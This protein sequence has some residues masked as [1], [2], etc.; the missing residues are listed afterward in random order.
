[1]L[2]YS[3]GTDSGKIFAIFWSIFNLSAVLGGFITFVYFSSTSSSGNVALFFIFLGLIMAGAFGALG[4]EAPTALLK[5]SPKTSFSHDRTLTSPILSEDDDT[6]DTKQPE[7]V[8]SGII[9]A[10]EE[11]SDESWVSE[12]GATVILFTDPRMARMALI[13]FYTG[14]NQPY[15]LVTFGNRFF[16]PS[17]LGLMVALFYSAE[18]VGAFVSAKVVDAPG[19]VRG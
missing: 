12:F 15:Q 18:L 14:F 10:S 7:S 3:D 13:Y 4:L 9:V 6:A 16:T 19:K 11:I 2:Q 5:K 8:G 1:M 17:T